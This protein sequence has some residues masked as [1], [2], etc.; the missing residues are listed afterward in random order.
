MIQAHPIVNQLSENFVNIS[1]KLYGARTPQAI[2]AYLKRS[3][4]L[5]LS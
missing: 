1:E 2:H 5:M 3:N 4:A